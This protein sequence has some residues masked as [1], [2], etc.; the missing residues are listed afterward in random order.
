MQPDLLERQARKVR[1]VLLAHK[2]QPVRPGPQAQSV[3]PDLPDLPELQERKVRKALLE[4]KAQ[5]VR[6]GHPAWFGKGH[7][8]VLRHMR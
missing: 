2:A 7:G 3:Q 6:R 8:A 1:R 5:P 4:H